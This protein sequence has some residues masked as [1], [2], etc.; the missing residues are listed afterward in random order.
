MGLLVEKIKNQSPENVIKKLDNINSFLTK[1]VRSQIKSKI[2]SK[3]LITELVTEEVDLKVHNKKHEHLG[4]ES[5][6][7]IEIVNQSRHI[8]I[9]S[10]SLRLISKD[11][12]LKSSKIIICHPTQSYGKDECDLK[13]N[14]FTLEAFGGIDYSNNQKLGKDL[15]S[16]CKSGNEKKKFLA[17]YTDINL[18]SKFKDA[19]KFYVLNQKSIKKFK[20]T[21]ET[22][23]MEVEIVD[24][25]KSGNV[26]LLEIKIKHV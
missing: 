12:K 15:W 11:T 21:Y 16:L 23:K 22:K 25:K 6:N 3:D 10:T 13:S 5:E 17:F 26:T 18:P 7:L 14:K 2:D 19:L 1:K 4:K 20:I 24:L 9:L 8:S